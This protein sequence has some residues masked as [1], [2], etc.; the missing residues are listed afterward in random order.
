MS[1]AGIVIDASVCLSWAFEDEADSLADSVLDNLLAG[2]A[3]VPAF[4]AAEVANALVSGRRR[5]RIE[6]SRI[7]VFLTDIGTLDIRVDV[8]P[9]SVRTLVEMAEVTGL[10]AYDAAY[11]VLALDRELPLATKDRHMRDAARRVGVEVLE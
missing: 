6:E 7:K 5:G 4:W 9:P 11:V 3:S 1:A 2:F 10:T 8:E